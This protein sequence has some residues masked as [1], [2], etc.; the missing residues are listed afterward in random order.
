[1]LPLSHLKVIL[2]SDGSYEKQVVR[3]ITTVGGVRLVPSTQALQLFRQRLPTLDVAHLVDEL[4]S[5]LAPDRSW[6]TTVVRKHTTDVVTSI[7]VLT[8]C[9]KRALHVV[10]E[11]L[12]SE[13]RDEAAPLLGSETSLETLNVLASHRQPVIRRLVTNV[14]NIAAQLLKIS[15]SSHRIVKTKKVMKELGVSYGEETTQDHPVQTRIESNRVNVVQKEDLVTLEHTAHP[16]LEASKPLLPDLT[17]E[18]ESPKTATPAPT[19]TWAPPP[20]FAPIELQPSPSATSGLEELL[21][22]NTSDTRP[23]H[24]PSDGSRIPWAYPPGVAVAYYVPYIP[25]AYPP[26]YGYVFKT[27]EFHPP[28][29]LRT[30]LKRR[31]TIGPG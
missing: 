22:L 7:L 29:S 18:P 24:F 10:L 30:P 4:L 28:R 21:Q 2:L 1:M 20:T 11:V 25:A 15:V 17:F 31:S 5:F 8:R 14:R 16:K 19:P 12:N 9:L 23:A 13:R 26:P 3:E 27:I 6:Q